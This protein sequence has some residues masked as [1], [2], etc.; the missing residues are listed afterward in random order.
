[1]IFLNQQSLQ[2]LCMML[3]L[4]VAHT[5]KHQRLGNSICKLLCH[6]KSGRFE[7]KK[8]HSDTNYQKSE[9]KM[10]KVDKSRILEYFVSGTKKCFSSKI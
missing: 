10:Y 3:R 4:F 1:M 6:G 2:N 7:T 8:T 5:Q 9:A